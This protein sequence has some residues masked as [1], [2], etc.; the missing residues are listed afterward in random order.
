MTPTNTEQLNSEAPGARDRV[1]SLDGVRGIAILAIMAFHSGVT[2]LDVGGFFS[3][4]A[5]FVLSGMLITLILLREWNRTRSIGLG[6]FYIRRIRRLVPALLVMLIL[7][8]VYVDLVAPAGMYPGFRGDALSVLGYFSNWHFIAVKANYFQLSNAPSLLTHTWS[9]AIEEQFY[10]VWPLIVIG[11]MRVTRRHRIQGL[12]ALF[13][14]SLAGALASMAWMAH[15]FRA[16]ASETRLYYGSDTHSQ[17]ILIGCALGSALAIVKHRRG[18]DSLL[19]VAQSTAGRRILSVVGILSFVGL[20]W[21]WTHLGPANPFTYEGGFLVGALLTAGILVSASCAPR[22]PLARALSIR[23][24]RAIGA[25]SYGMYLWY[26]PVFQ[27]IDGARTGQT[28]TSLFLIRVAIDIGM[29]TLS[30]FLLELPVRRRTLFTSKHH[31]RNRQGASFALFFVSIVATIGVVLGTTAGSALPGGS[32]GAS[33]TASSTLAPTAATTR[34][35]MIGDST[36]LTLGDALPTQGSSWNVAV[37]QQGVLGCGVA[38][39]PVV[40]VNGVLETPGIPCLSSTPK[41]GQWPDRLKGLVATD[42]PNVVVFLAGRWEVVDRV[43]QGHWTNILAP[44]F[45][46]YIKDQLRSLVRIGTSSGAHLVFL[47]A[48]CYSSG[49]QPDGSPWPE[50]SAVRLRAYND[51]LYQVAAEYPLRVSVVNLN[52]KICPGGV[53]RTTVDG[54]LVRAPDGVHFP[55]FTASAPYAA[56]PDNR[57]QARAFGKWIGPWLMPKLVAS[58]HPIPR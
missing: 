15:L 37:D 31:Q 56:E 40:R 57:A 13:S 33:A 23:A 9:L 36:A 53:Y 4:D 12:V 39:G 50:D 55:Y 42:K 26:F 6:G 38:I 51:L 45:R 30:Y 25:I 3:Q 48:P 17:S 35:L 18:I 1:G 41:I 46:D 21:Q 58:A 49:E 54:V 22:G 52:A 43:Y 20:A 47:T 14:V 5:F 32:P 7:V 11:V 28:G 34:L 27:Y 29:A 19:P 16:G 10:L 44:A 8:S 24:L 2:G